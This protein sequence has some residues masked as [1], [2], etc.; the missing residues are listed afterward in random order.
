MKHLKKKFCVGGLELDNNIFYAPLAG[1]SDYPFRKMAISPLSSS[2]PGLFFCE[3]V[4]IDALI[5]HEPTTY[6]LLDYDTSMHPIGAQICGSKIEYVKDACQIVEGLGFDWIDLN[7]GCP[8]DK[9]TK[10]GSGSA[11]LQNPKKIGEILEK[12][13]SSVSIPVS[14]K[15]RS[16]WDEDSINAPE[17]T[18]IAENSGA[19]IITIHGRTRQQA[20]KGFAA[21]SPIKEAK[22]AAKT[23]KVFGNGDVFDPLSAEKMFLE[24]GADG[25]L[26]ARGTMGQP[27]IIDEIISY[28]DTG[29]FKERSF[30]EIKDY[31][32]EHFRHILLYQNDK[33][34]LLDMRRV[35]SWFLKKLPGASCLRKVITQGTDPLKVLQEIEEFSWESLEEEAF[36]VSG[37]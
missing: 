9:I 11:L 27:W 35:G 24:T 1:C 4:K 3:M 31:F 6:R 13:K 21:F 10:D 2:R 28:L 34:A 14:V 22:K 26:V 18:K 8:V 25:V 32:L 37:S 7:C 33:K 19:S 29:T 36:Q 15:I 5:R 20:Y 17:I 23:I 16:G 30:L 12:M